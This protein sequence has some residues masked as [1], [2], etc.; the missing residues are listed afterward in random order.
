MVR[1]RDI[2]L[3]VFPLLLPFTSFPLSVVPCPVSVPSCPLPVVSCPQI[4]ASLALD[5]GRPYR[6]WQMSLQFSGEANVM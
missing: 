1:G 2:L 3:P 6:M 5:A 4:K